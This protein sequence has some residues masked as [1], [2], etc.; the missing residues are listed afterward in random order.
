[1]NEDNPEIACRILRK[2]P[3]MAH[4]ISGFRSVFPGRLRHGPCEHL[5]RHCHRDPFA[6]IVL[7]G[8]YCEAGDRG[9][10]RVTA[11]D[12]L[13]HGPYE[14]HLDC[15]DRI[16]VDQIVLPWNIPIPH[17][18]IGHI[19][20]PDLLAR[21]A[22]R[23]PHEA[24][25]CLEEHLRPVVASQ[26]DWPDRLAHDLGNDPDLGIHAW[27]D[28]AQL[29]RESVSRGFRRVYGVAPSA[30]R[31]R[32]RTLKALAMIARGGAL[33]DIAAACGFSDQSH[34][35]RNVHRLTGHS[36]RQFRSV[37]HAAHWK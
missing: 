15:T 19:D 29:R 24:A 37:A 27:A 14:S 12:V 18:H 8:G 3:T 4:S 16:S 25:C 20:D 17:F 9:R 32:A 21:I 28:R 30:F 1:L 6:A 33:A 35:N 2:S 13:L 11:G 10:A 22:E 34:M 36:P 23:D 7:A 26:G 5:P 31:A